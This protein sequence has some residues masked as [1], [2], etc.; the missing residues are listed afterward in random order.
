MKK[1]YYELKKVEEGEG[2]WLASAAFHLCGLCSGVI[3]TMGGPGYGS[4]CIKCGDA[5]KNGQLRGCVSWDEE[6]PV[7]AG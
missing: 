4:I 1:E 3:D 5:L 6:P 2:N 7:E